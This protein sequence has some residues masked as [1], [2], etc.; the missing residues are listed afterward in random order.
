MNYRKIIILP[1]LFILSN[2]LYISCCKCVDSD[3][4]FYIVGGLTVKTS[5]SGTNFI[6]PGPS[7]TVDSI[8]LH[9]DLNSK[10][11]ASHQNPLS[12]LVNSSYACKCNECGTEGL[13]HKVA[14]IEITSD[15][16]YNGIAAGAPLND[17]F[18]VQSYG[19]SYSYAYITLNAF[20]DEINAVDSR[21]RNVV[22][23]LITTKPG[24]NLGHSFKIK[25]IFDDGSVAMVSSQTLYWT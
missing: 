5:I 16:V 19:S 14:S 4:G 20:K 2:L 13:K 10:C 22:R 9:Y 1:A 24:N 6:D 3:K 25:I 15:S 18:K 7:T 11:V 17:L 23:M 8:F 21:I 12:F